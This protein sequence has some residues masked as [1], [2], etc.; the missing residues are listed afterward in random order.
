M[1]LLLVPLLINRKN[2]FTTFKGKT[3]IFRM[4][5]DT[6]LLFTG[7]F[8]LWRSPAGLSAPMMVKLTAI[9]L[10]IFFFV[11]GSKKYNGMFI[12]SALIIWIYIYGISKTHNIMLKPYPK[13]VENITDGKELYNTLCA[14]CHG[15]DGKAN[16]LG[17]KNL[18]KNNFSQ[19]HI[20]NTI[21]NGGKIMPKFDYLADEQIQ[22]ITK[23][24]EELKNK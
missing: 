13:Q 3:K 7:V 10:M 8:L 19:E 15:Y 1:L 5:L 11:L 18:I 20:A 12:I 6:L 22:A 14:R 24:V 2:L 16:F 9:L 23:Y 17:A 4:V 21:K